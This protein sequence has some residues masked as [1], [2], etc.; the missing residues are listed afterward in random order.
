MSTVFVTGGSG[1]IGGALPAL[2]AAGHHTIALARGG[3][4]TTRVAA[5]GAT[6]VRADLSDHTALAGAMNGCDAVI[7]AAARV[8]SGAAPD[9]H[10][11]NVAGTRIALAAA[12]SMGYA[13]S[14]TSGR[15]AASSAADARS[16]TPTSPGRCTSPATRPT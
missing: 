15:P 8:R 13:V 10:R 14:C 11:D 9:F 4:A 3:P 2:A 1:F 7:H 5:L 6:P 16:S 12:Q